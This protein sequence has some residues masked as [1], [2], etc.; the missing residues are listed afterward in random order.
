MFPHPHPRAAIPFQPPCLSYT[1]AIFQ[2][3]RVCVPLNLRYRT[4]RAD[5]HVTSRREP[6]LPR[7]GESRLASSVLGDSPPYLTLATA[8]S[9]NICFPFDGLGLESLPRLRVSSLG[10]GLYTAYGVQAAT[11][12]IPLSQIPAPSPSTQSFFHRRYGV[13]YQVMPLPSSCRASSQ[14]TPSQAQAESANKGCS[15][16]WKPAAN[17]APSPSRRRSRSPW[18]CTY[19]TA[20]SAAAS[21]RRPSARAPSSRASRCPTPS[22]CAAT[23]E[24]PVCRGPFFPPV[25]DQC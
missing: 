25:T 2:Q 1:A 14:L 6:R 22:C 21:R 15:R 18:R 4:A 16:P 8:E 12:W 11:T 7:P 5:G 19:A 13:L 24:S 9:R 23:R 3:S 10:I 17:A 20:T